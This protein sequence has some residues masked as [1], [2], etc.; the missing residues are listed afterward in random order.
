MPG[1][2]APGAGRGQ[3]GADDDKHETPDYLVNAENTDEL[4]G[5]LPP[6]IPGGVLGADIPA[7]RPPERD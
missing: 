1:M 7:A 4:L 2:M 6:T 3:Q 5:E